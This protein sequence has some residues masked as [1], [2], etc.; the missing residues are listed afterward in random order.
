MHYVGY[1]GSI[2]PYRNKHDL[3]TDPVLCSLNPMVRCYTS[4]VKH[5]YNTV[6]T[7]LQVLL[8]GCT[9]NAS[10]V[11]QGKCWTPIQHGVSFNEIAK[12]FAMAYSWSGNASLLRASENAFQ[13]LADYDTQVRVLLWCD[14][15]AGVSHSITPLTYINMFCTPSIHHR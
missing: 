12:V 1:Y 13:M 3:Y 11:A 2:T 9:S 15:Y 14:Y 5:R 4:P 6:T 10:L 7:P 8:S